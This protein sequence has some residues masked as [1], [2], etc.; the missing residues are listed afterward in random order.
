M[1]P[2]EILAV[3][4]LESETITTKQ[5]NEDIFY[6]RMALNKRKAVDLT[7]KGAYEY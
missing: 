4:K 7:F 3:S 1:T 2:A 6:A 5:D